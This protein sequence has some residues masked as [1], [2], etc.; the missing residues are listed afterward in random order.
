[1]G[2]TSFRNI[3]TS[4]ASA[5]VNENLPSEDA[6]DHFGAAQRTVVISAQHT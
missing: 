2:I 3:N 4:R 6:V 1:M 5:K